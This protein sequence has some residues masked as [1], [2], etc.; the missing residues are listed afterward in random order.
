M[1]GVSLKWGEQLLLRFCRDPTLSLAIAIACL[2]TAL[3]GLLHLRVQKWKLSGVLSEVT[4]SGRAP[5]SPE[6]NC[7]CQGGKQKPSKV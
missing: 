4:V 2:S 6:P 1:V 5:P 3:R 7:L